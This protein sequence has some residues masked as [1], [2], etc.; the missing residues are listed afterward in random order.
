MSMMSC[1]THVNTESAAAILSD[2]CP[3]TEVLKTVLVSVTHSKYNHVPSKFYRKKEKDL[4]YTEST[5][6]PHGHSFNSF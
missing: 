2:F 3:K 6:S 5:D 1:F 4:F